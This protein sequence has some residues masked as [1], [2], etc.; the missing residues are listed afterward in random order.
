MFAYRYHLWVIFASVIAIQ[1]ILLPIFRPSVVIT[2]QAPG[3]ISNA[4]LDGAI[5]F[6]KA[7]GTRRIPPRSEVTSHRCVT[8]SFRLEGLSAT[9]MA[10]NRIQPLVDS[11]ILKSFCEYRGIFVKSTDELTKDDKRAFLAFVTQEVKADESQ[12]AAKMQELLRS[13]EYTMPPEIHAMSGGKTG[14]VSGGFYSA[15]TIVEGL[16]AVNIHVATDVQVGLDF[17]GSTGRAVLALSWAFQN[18]EWHLSDPIR[19]SI[20][21]AKENLEGIQSLASPIVPPLS[22]GEGQ[23]DLV[24]AV[25]IWSHYNPPTAGAAWFKEMH[26]IIRTGG[27]LVVTT[28]GWPALSHRLVSYE[29]KEP[30]S[31]GLQAKG[32]EFISVFPNNTDWDPDT[33]S[34]DW[35]QSFIDLDWLRVTLGPLWHILV[36]LPGLSDCNQDVIVLQRI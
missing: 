4:I 20:K 2:D 23:F 1:F 14:F 5:Y 6:Q 19:A 32:Y 28:H 33:T 9:F 31:T 16:A 10:F 27:T 22:Y 13:R 36:V 18:V 25:S 8:E 26:R 35:G 12:A 7:D 15:D 30:I 24:F 29:S 11:Q 34:A 3:L 17:G 21:W